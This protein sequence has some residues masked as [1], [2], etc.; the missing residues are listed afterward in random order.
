M[1]RR[2]VIEH[3]T[4]HETTNNDRFLRRFGMDDEKR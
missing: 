3:L 4:W 2:I 1:G